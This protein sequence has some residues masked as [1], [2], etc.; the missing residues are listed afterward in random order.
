[1][2]KSKVAL[3]VLLC[4]VGILMRVTRAETAGMTSRELMQQCEKVEKAGV[5]QDGK[6]RL[7]STG[8][9]LC[10]GY[11]KAYL[12]IS[13]WQKDGASSNK[14]LVNI[15]LPMPK[16]FDT[17]QFMRMF[18]DYARKE[19]DKI[20]PQAEMALANM[21]AANFQC[22]KDTISPSKKP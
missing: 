2:R 18:L 10:W 4:F 5:A 9:G 17:L 19:A 7:R 13:Q 12:A 11:L 14:M 16:E 8:A 1:M 3:T 22:G 21:L 6:V 20:A 15:C